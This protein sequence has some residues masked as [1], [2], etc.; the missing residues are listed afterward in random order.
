MLDIVCPNCGA[1]MEWEQA[2]EQAP[3]AQET[4]PQQV[5]TE[6]KRV[7]TLS[8]TSTYEAHTS[9]T[10]LNIGSHLQKNFI[11]TLQYFFAILVVHTIL[12]WWFDEP[13]NSPYWIIG[14][15]MI[16][17]VGIL[18]GADEIIG[19]EFAGNF[20]KAD[21]WIAC[22][23]G[24]LFWGCV[25]VFAVTIM[26]DKNSHMLRWLWGFLSIKHQ[27]IFANPSLLVLEGA[28]N[29]IGVICGFF[30]S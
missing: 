1:K 15:E 2:Q 17:G 28:V 8:N 29:A 4:A 30:K 18:V 12:F 25:I 16:F 5:T 9:S 24:L 6:A 20:G 10:S 26:E 14:I 7:S 21:T 19:D 11:L 22:L 3:C 13:N 27:F 23:L